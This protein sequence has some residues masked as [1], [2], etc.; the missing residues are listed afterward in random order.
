[1][2]KQLEEMHA[3]Y[4]LT[5][6]VD[7]ILYFDYVDVMRNDLNGTSFL[8]DW[9]DEGKLNNDMWRAWEVTDVFSNH[10]YDEKFVVLLTKIDIRNNNFK[11]EVM[12]TLDKLH[13]ANKIMYGAA[14]EEFCMFFRIHIKNELIKMKGEE[15]G[16]TRSNQDNQRR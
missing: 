7:D 3:N 2:V 16:S 14:Y 11:E 5:E 6:I 13:E 15:N 8:Y 10:K 4:F 9:F 12:K 1:M